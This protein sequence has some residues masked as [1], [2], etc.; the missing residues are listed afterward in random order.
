MFKPRF[1]SKSF[2]LGLLIISTIVAAGIAAPKIVPNNPLEQNLRHRLKGP[3]STYPLGTDYLGRCV[4][5]RLIYA[6][7]P[8]IGLALTVTIITSLIGMAVGITAGCFPRLDGLIMRITDCFFAFPGIV[9]ALLCI[10]ITGPGLTGLILA[11]SIPGWPKFARVARSITRTAMNGL[12]VETV[13]AMGAGRIYIIRTCVLPK[14]WPQITTI[15]TIGVSGKV[16]AI[17][18]LGFLGLGIQP[19][20]PEWGTMMSKGL[21]TLAIAPHIP[22]LAGL[23]IAVS[24]M[25]FTLAGEGLRDMLDPHC[26][27][28]ALSSPQLEEI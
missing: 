3:D 12:H 24:A 14:L 11:I 27:K 25:G 5:S 7:R 4:A 8:S 9:A 21:P 15:A 2:I 22:L 26:Y 16:T 1:I 6:I 13:R 23:C 10:A 19:P 17:A 18:G 28:K 20:T